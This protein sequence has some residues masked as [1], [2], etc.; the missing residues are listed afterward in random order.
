MTADTSGYRSRIRLDRNTL[1]VDGIC[2][3]QS[4][5]ARGLQ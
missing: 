2:A 3:G 5:G 1:I 4:E